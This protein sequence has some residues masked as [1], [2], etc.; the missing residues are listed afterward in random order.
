MGVPLAA[1]ASTATKGREGVWVFAHGVN[2]ITTCLLSHT[3]TDHTDIKLW[4]G[5]QDG[6]V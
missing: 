5:G 1:I 6:T 4:G 3:E 2:N